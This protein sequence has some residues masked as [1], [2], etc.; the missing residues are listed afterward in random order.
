MWSLHVHI[1]TKECQSSLKYGNSVL[2]DNMDDY[3]RH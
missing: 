1:E 2:Y 3:G